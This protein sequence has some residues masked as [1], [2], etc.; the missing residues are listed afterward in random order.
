MIIWHQMSFVRSGLRYFYFSAELF[1]FL[2]CSKIPPNLTQNLAHDPNPPNQIQPPNGNP[3][4]NPGARDQPPKILRKD[5]RA[6]VHAVQKNCR[7]AVQS[8]V[9]LGEPPRGNAHPHGGH[10]RQILR[11]DEGAGHRREEEGPLHSGEGN[12]V[13]LQNPERH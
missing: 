6:R 7:E 2:K 4:E 5:G 1:H 10:S 12:E 8:H 13:L 11:L 3:D 9:L